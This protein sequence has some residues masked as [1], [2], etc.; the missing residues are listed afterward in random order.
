[1]SVSQCLAHLQGWSCNLCLLFV[2][3]SC[4]CPPTPFLLPLSQHL[5]W[6]RAAGSSFYQATTTDSAAVDQNKWHLHKV[7]LRHSVSCCA[8]RDLFIFLENI[9]KSPL[10]VH[11]AHNPHPQGLRVA[12]INRCRDSGLRG[13]IQ[14]QSLA[15]LGSFI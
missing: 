7:M 4:V 8:I 13:L 9:H 11:V 6:S 3:C 14:I 2:P 15:F 10:Y 12:T 5:T 1:M